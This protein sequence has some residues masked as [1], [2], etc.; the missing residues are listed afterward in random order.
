VRTDET[1]ADVVG[2]DGERESQRRFPLSLIASAS[3]SR[4]SSRSRS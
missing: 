1:S 4:R 2:D 3:R